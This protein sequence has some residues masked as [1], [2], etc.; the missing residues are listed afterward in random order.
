MK[1][2]PPA[3][4]VRISGKHNVH[5]FAHA[6]VELEIMYSGFHLIIIIVDIHTRKKVQITT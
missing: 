5:L 4:A 2:L 3:V 6:R 1:L